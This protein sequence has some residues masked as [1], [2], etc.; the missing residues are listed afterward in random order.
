VRPH[1]GASRS[2][3]VVLLVLY[4]V[5]LPPLLVETAI[6]HK[7]IVGGVWRH[8]VRGGRL[9]YLDKSSY[10][11]QVR[12]ARDEWR[13]ASTIRLREVDDHNDAEIRVTDANSC[14]V[15]WIGQYDYSVDRVR[16]NK[17]AMN[18]SGGTYP[19]TGENLGSTTSS[20]KARTAVHEFG[21]ALG[22]DHNS[23][24]ACNSILYSP[25]RFDAVTCYIPT[26]HDRNDMAS[27]WP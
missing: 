19:G 22:L 6:A 8:S 24:G 7:L 2:T 21:H 17:C 25:V 4:G 26:S 3:I 9:D 18:W 14:D 16:F 5:L 13:A 23:L 27:Y 11:S 20:R 12:I 15:A 1:R 10:G